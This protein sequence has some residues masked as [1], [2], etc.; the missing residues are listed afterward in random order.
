[1]R[2]RN[3]NIVD[4][5]EERTIRQYHA[6][7]SYQSEAPDA[8]PTQKPRVSPAEVYDEVRSALLASVMVGGP[9]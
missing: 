3:L 5:H 2:R 8:P 4:A 7:E 9:V 1:M 6:R